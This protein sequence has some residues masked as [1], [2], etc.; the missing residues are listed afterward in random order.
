MTAQNSPSS[1]ESAPQQAVLLYCLERVEGAARRKPARTRQHGGDESSVTFDQSDA[2]PLEEHGLPRLGLA[3][4]AQ[5]SGELLTQLPKSG[6]RRCRP[7]RHHEVQ[8][9]GDLGQRRVK[10]LPEPPSDGVARHR[11]SHPPGD[12]EAQARRAELVGKSVHGEQLA[13]VSGALPVDPFKIRRVGQACALAPRQRSDSQPLTTAPAAGGNDPA[14]THRAHALAKTVRLGPLSA[15]RLVSALHKNSSIGALNSVDDPHSISDATVAI[16]HQ[17]PLNKE[18]RTTTVRRS[19]GGKCC[20]PE[21]NSD[22]AMTDRRSRARVCGLREFFEC[23]RRRAFQPVVH[24][25][26]INMWITTLISCKGG[27]FRQTL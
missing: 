14:P 16:Q 13:P 5:R 22:E 21:A 10:D 1:H 27:I 26:W 15:V 25:L 9:A 12:G 3:E 2:N 19:S 23:L 11:V 8:V 4:L 7:R 18:P 24:S 17:R 20:K 6:L